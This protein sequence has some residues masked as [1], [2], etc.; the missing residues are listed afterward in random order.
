MSSLMVRARKPGWN[1]ISMLHSLLEK[2]QSKRRFGSHHSFV[3][4]LDPTSVQIL[5]DLK[6]NYGSNWESYLR[7]ETRGYDTIDQ[8]LG[9]STIQNP[10]TS[11]VSLIPLIKNILT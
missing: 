10:Q 3:L 1:V 7:A 2:R 5:K 6:S 4:T 8:V 9:D 11:H